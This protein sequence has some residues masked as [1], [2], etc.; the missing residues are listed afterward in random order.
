VK[1]NY[2]L[3][4]LKLRKIVEKSKKNKKNEMWIDLE[5][6]FSKDQFNSK[7][8]KDLYAKYNN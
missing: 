3:E 8:F 4:V 5:K 2:F 1:R 6:L 7:D